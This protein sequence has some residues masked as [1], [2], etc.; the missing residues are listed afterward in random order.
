[1]SA[2]KSLFPAEKVLLNVLAFNLLKQFYLHGSGV[3]LLKVHN[4]INIVLL[5]IILSLGYTGMLIYPFISCSYQGI[6]VF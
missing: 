5:T 6:V 3:D 4:T 2:L 1:M